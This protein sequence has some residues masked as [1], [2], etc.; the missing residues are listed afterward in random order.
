MAAAGTR[1]DY[2]Y[3]A[4][5][6]EKAER[7][8]DMVHYTT[9]VA[10]MYQPLSFDE[11]NLL[12]VAFKN[13]VGVRRMA[14]RVINENEQ[15]DAHV[16][17]PEAMAKIAEYKRKVEV[18]LDSSCQAILSL[19]QNQLIGQADGED[20]VF[21]LKMKGDYYRY[22]AEFKDHQGQEFAE[23]SSQAELA[24]GE[25]L[26]FAKTCLSAAHPIRL[27][28][29]LNYSVFHHE[30]QK[31]TTKATVLARDTVTEATADLPNLL[32]DHQA[33]AQQILAL[34]QENLQLWSQGAGEDG[35]AV[36]EL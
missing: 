26:A 18:E 36:E 35:T 30:V 3:M 9:K 15:S 5:I 1:S 33:D 32:V 13:S 23:C 4:K 20:K 17:G 27:G 6:A 24:Y 7:Y 25:A 21:Y 10:E 31:S 19:L 14:W 34:L 22:K 2:V 28:L 8:E 12:S 16:L 29:A 11:R